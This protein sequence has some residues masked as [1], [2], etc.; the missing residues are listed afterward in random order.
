MDVQLLL[1]PEYLASWGG[2]H[3]VSYPLLKDSESQAQ[4]G[5]VGRERKGA[6]GRGEREGRPLEER[7][8]AAQL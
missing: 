7:V 3:G 2:S 8:L 5:R 1:S 6:G 4:K